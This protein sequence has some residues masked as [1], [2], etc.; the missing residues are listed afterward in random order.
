MTRKLTFYL[1]LVILS[2]AGLLPLAVMFG[3]SVLVDGHLSLAYYRDL[4]ISGRALVLLGNSFKLAL[5]TSFLATAIGIPVGILLGKTDLPG[6]GIFALV[7]SLPLLVPPYITAVAWFGILGKAGILSRF[8]GA[9][10]GTWT[11]ARLFD[12]TGCVLVLFSTF[13]P[14]IVLMT[15]VLLR[16]VNPRL[17]EAARLVAGWG[18]VLW[19]VTIPLI[20]PGILI[21]AT[22]VFLL[23]LGE[24]G[25][26][27]FLR[28]EVFPVESFTQF[29]AFLNFGAAT[30][31]A[32]PL[33]VVTLIVLGA[34]WLLLRNKIQ[35][36][37]PA[38]DQ[39]SESQI[40]LGYATAP[41]FLLVTFLGIVLVVVPFSGLV[42]QSG[43][44]AAYIEAWLRAGGS[45]IRSVEYAAIGASLLTVFGFFV[46]YLV[47]SKAMRI[48]RAADAFTLLL[49]AMPGTVIGI[50]LVTLWNHPSTTFIYGTPAIILL[51]YLAQYTALTSRFTVAALDQIPPAMEEAARLAGAGWWRRLAWI[52]VPLAVRG[53]IAA[54]LAAYVF[55]LRD[56]SISM[57][58][59]PPGYDL[60]TTR[61]FTL[62]ANG[63]PQ[64]I[65]ALCVILIGAAIIPLAAFSTL[66]KR[67]H[68][69]R[70][71]Y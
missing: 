51:G 10:A 13:L 57:L 46:G 20:L 19:G 43:S 53:L 40:R 39:T 24:L 54:W 63:S 38:A 29:S 52:V 49:F 50:G 37:R 69:L 60:F 30:A 67:G 45:L 6:R 58:V 16:T 4:F 22:L 71:V 5:C 66:F 44:V 8:V 28:Y 68:V 31:A 42:I 48:W 59:Y 56:L 70:G 61:T 7:L 9:E 2:V 64:M 1:V 23:V 35:Q 27:M 41:L 12:L 33:A 14:I 65:A 26:P 47:H 3:K 17:E 36:L 34:E 18:S 25:V 15:M 21:A 55:C 32:M 62:M 11:S